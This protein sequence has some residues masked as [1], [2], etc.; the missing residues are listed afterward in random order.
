VKINC[1][2]I[3]ESLVES[4]LF[5]H[6][7]GAFTSAVKARVGKF[8][9]ANGG[10][11]LLD[12]IGEMPLHAQAKLLRVLQER[13]VT[14]IGGD[15]E[16]PVDVRVL[17]TTNRD[18]KVEVEKGNFRE[19]LY[20]RLNVIPLRAPPQRD[21]LGDLEVLARH[22][23]AKYNRENGFTVPG[24][25]A[26]ALER[27]QRHGWPGN[28]REL[29]N[30]IQRAVVFAKSREI[31]VEHLRLEEVESH[32][33]AERSESLAAGMTVADAER[34]LI[35][36]TL[37]AAAQNRTKAAEMLGISI[38]TLRNKLHEYKLQSG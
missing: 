24:L 23:I 19:D 1:A 33:T 7:K 2:A 11:L 25:S 31:G 28:V 17:C 3:H 30:V 6:E 12:E 20:Y 21:R 15:E 16:V 27:L 14:K 5:G 34:L 37:E 32:R 18:L 8:E 38:R 9:L 10:T 22:F 29:E 13:E 4:E 36:R 35:L 26:P